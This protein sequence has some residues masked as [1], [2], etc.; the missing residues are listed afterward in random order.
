MIIGWNT[1]GAM[2]KLNHDSSFHL[3]KVTAYVD[4]STRLTYETLKKKNLLFG[5]I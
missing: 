2:E 1:I 5:V 3:S 4:D